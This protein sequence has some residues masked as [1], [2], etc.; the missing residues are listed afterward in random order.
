M[1]LLIRIATKAALSG[2]KHLHPTMYLLIPEPQGLIYKHLQ[3]FTSHYVSINSHICTFLYMP[4]KNLHPTMYLLIP[5][6]RFSE[7]KSVLYLHPT[8][9]LL[10]R[11]VC[12]NK[13]YTVQFTSHYVSINSIFRS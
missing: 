12:N 3:P 2:C 1:Y 10:I 6:T 7:L 8:M 5:F 11:N 4:H 9:Y 13:A